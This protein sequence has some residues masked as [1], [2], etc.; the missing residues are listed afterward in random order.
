MIKGALLTFLVFCILKSD[1]QTAIGK[2]AVNKQTQS[3]NPVI[4][5]FS[6]GDKGVIEVLNWVRQNPKEFVKRILLNPEYE[7]YVPSNERDWLYTSLISD[8]NKMEPIKTTLIYN[9]ELYGY[10]FCHAKTSGE[11][12]VV[13]H[14]RVDTT[15]GHGFVAECIS[16]GPSDPIEIV[17]NLLVDEGNPGLGHRKILLANKFSLAG[18][19]IQSHSTYRYNC[20]IDLK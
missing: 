6:S 14:K 20:V 8:L 17:F 1:A 7:N 4:P 12:G 16:Y 15:C 3:P 9:E 2:F 10:A 11:L 5:A 18:V 13:S 19:S